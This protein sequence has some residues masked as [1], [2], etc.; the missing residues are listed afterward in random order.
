MFTLV[1]LNLIAVFIPKR[2]TKAEMYTTSLFALLWGHV[3]D[4][5]LDIKLSLYYYF[6]RGLQW[7]D[8]FV[9]FLI[10][11]AVSVLFL[12][13]YPNKKGLFYKI[14]Y[15]TGWSIFSVVFEWLS[16]RTRFFTHVRWKLWHSA[17][18]YPFLF[19]ILLWHLRIVRKLMK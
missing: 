19:L 16:A 1:A 18:L 9:P 14:C 10:Y 6:N 15:I 17:L 8:F 4:M 5:A 11:P 2:L 12:N 3:V 7:R 13:L